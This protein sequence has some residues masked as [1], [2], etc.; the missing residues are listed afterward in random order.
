MSSSTSSSEPWRR[1]FRQIAGTLAIAACVLFGFVAIVDPFDTL[2]LSPPLPRVPVASNQRFAYPSLA[3]SDKF[4]AAVFGTSSSRLLRPA[5]LNPTFGARF[6]NLAMND[7]TVWEQSRLFALFA[8]AH[9]DAKALILGLDYRWCVTGSDYQRV[10]FRGFPEA[11]YQPTRWPA[12]REMFNMY[13]LQSAGQLFG[14]M[15]GIKAQD[16]GSDGYTRFVPPDSDY[17]AARAMTHILRDGITVPVGERSGPP[18]SWTFPAM[19][20]LRTMLGRLPTSATKIVYFVPYNVRL[21]PP[22]DHTGAPV[23][24]ECKAR[25]AAVAKDFANTTVV[26]FLF[27]SP[28]T[29]NDENYW[30]GI[31]YR[32]SIA[33]RL[34]ADMKAAVNGQQ[35]EDYR[36]LRK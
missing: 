28:I 19:P 29:R 7:S 36:I 1:F 11:L 34:I 30:D 16:Q 15:T 33:D 25:V 10:T 9:P 18:E 24:T 21:Q 23:W 4:D 35:S 31:H 14:V 20:A 12:Y 8:D 27:P 22:A 2:P 13:A 5:V 32:L 6:A 3:R 26:D 17:D